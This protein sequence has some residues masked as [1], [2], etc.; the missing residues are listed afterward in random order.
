[1]VWVSLH[2]GEGMLSS[3]TWGVSV[4]TCNTTKII[5]AAPDTG[6]TGYFPLVR[7]KD[8]DGHLGLAGV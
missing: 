1:M 2:I 8:Y 3:D 5:P 7:I 4:V 6:E